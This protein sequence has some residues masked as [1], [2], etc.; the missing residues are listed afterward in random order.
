MTE[1]TGDGPPSM[2]TYRAG[3]HCD[4][5]KEERRLYQRKLRANRTGQC[6]VAGCNTPVETRDLCARCYQ[7]WRTQGR[8]PIRTFCKWVSVAPGDTFHAYEGE[9]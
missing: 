9:G 3:C 8:P 2:K 5:C 7:R 1:H 6:K 4:A